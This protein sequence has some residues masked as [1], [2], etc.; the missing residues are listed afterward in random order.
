M[1]RLLASGL[2]IALFLSAAA[3]DAQD[4]QWRAAGSPAPTSAVAPT[5]YAAPVSTAPPAGY[6]PPAAL[7][8][9]MAL[10]VAANPSTAVAPATAPQPA[11]TSS[12]PS[13]GRPISADPSVAAYPT[14]TLAQAPPPAPPDAY[15]CGPVT[16][17][18]PPPGML[19][20]IPPVGGSAP[21]GATPLF[22]YNWLGSLTGPNRQLLQSDHSFDNFVSP[23]TN[24]FL[25]EDPRSLTEIRPI[26]MVQATPNG[27]YL[28]RNGDAE[29]FGLQARVAVTERLSFVL[30]KFG[31]TWQDPQNGMDLLDKTGGWSE[32][33][34]GAK[35]TFYRN[36]SSGTVAAGGLQF[37]IPEGSNRVEQGT[38][39][40]SLVPYVSFAQNF[41]R[42][43]GLPLGGSFN[44]MNTTGYAFSVNDQR[45]DYFYSSFHLDYEIAHKIY[46]FLELNWFQYTQSG[47]STDI[48]FEGRDLFNFGSSGVSGIGTL[49]V[50]PGVRYKFTENIQAGIAFE[51]PLVSPKDLVDFRMT[52]DLIIRY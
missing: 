18:V 44:F 22:G 45:T 2:G 32:L 28:F 31:F 21:G 39:T 27:N 51:F 14:S 5:G 29:Y 30:S 42:N 23:V 41:G 1:R 47:R 52:I 40:L 25:F 19:N 17:P 34:M 9:P 48:G 7:G 37:Q 50:A 13:L 20:P 24:P 36:D 8:R 15:N 12:L 4:I 49:T 38:G 16:N 46:P 33:W 43:W 6:A 35:Y 11:V 10:D 3:A 26:F